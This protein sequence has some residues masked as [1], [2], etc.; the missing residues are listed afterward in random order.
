MWLNIICFN[1]V[2][3]V[4]ICD[5]LIGAV[6]IYFQLVSFR[7]CKRSSPEWKLKWAFLIPCCLSSICLSV[8]KLF[9]FHSWVKEIQV[10]TNGGPSPFQKGKNSDIVK[11]HWHLIFLKNS[12]QISTK[13]CTKHSWVKGIPI[14]L[15]E[16]SN[17][18]HGPLVDN[19][20]SNWN[21]LCLA[22]FICEKYQS[23]STILIVQ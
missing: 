5:F 2:W 23:N 21:Q 11:M 6:A 15:N 1:Y 4:F 13:L 10:C 22:I 8:Y 9:H 7:Y 18:V 20:Y 3:L 14:Y 12:L 17:V 19:K 16:V